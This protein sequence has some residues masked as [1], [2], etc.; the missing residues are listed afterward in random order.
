[1]NK[2]TKFLLLMIPAIFIIWAI[3]SFS[4]FMENREGLTYM[5]SLLSFHKEKLI[6]FLI[7]LI[8]VYIM[9]PYALVKMKKETN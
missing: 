4:E 6:D 8:P 1:M 9:V 7:S 5:A 2:K 3:H